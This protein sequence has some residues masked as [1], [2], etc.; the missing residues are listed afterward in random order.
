MT[1][2]SEQAPRRRRGLFGA[3]REHIAEDEE[4]SVDFSVD[5]SEYLEALRE[6]LDSF[7]ADARKA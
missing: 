1:D 4:M 6:S 7:V 2:P 5:F 3:F